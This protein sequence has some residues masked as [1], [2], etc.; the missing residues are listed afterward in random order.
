VDW[1]VRDGRQ[2]GGST[3]VSETEGRASSSRREKFCSAREHLPPFLHA[4]CTSIH[5]PSHSLDPKS[6]RQSFRPSVGRS[7][8][9]P[10][11]L[12]RAYSHLPSRLLA[13]RGL[14]RRGS[15]GASFGKRKRRFGRKRGEHMR[16]GAELR[17]GELP[18]D[19]EEEGDEGKTVGWRETERGTEIRGCRRPTDREPSGRCPPPPPPP[20]RQHVVVILVALAR[21]LLPH[22]LAQ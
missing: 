6:F 13:L 7:V 18:R 10:S 16:G 15:R 3:T 17:A 5:P 21:L 12:T 14:A 8:P 19:R 4:L 9:R 22:S 20:T 11:S 2:G 1:W